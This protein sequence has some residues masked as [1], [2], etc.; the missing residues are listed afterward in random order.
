MVFFVVDGL[1]QWFDGDLGFGSTLSN[2]PHA[3]RGLYGQAFFP[4]ERSLQVRA[5]DQ[6]VVELSA[7]HLNGDYTWGWDSTLT[8]CEPGSGPIAFRQSNLAARVV[9]A[10]WLRARGAGHRPQRGASTML[11]T[12][13]LGLV[14]GTR[15][16]DDIASALRAAHPEAF[17]DSESAFRFVSSGVGSLD[18]EDAVAFPPIRSTG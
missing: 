9:S 17:E 11:W 2:S 7:H 1:A 5:G 10:R 4:F 12:T 16:I 13:M 15:T 8:P 18:D 6:L 3:P 14:D